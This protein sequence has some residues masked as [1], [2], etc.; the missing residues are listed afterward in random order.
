VIP[1]AKITALREALEREGIVTFRNGSVV[2]REVNRI[3]VPDAEPG[4]DGEPA[5]IE[6]VHFVV[7]RGYGGETRFTEDEIRRA[8]EMALNGP[9]PKR[10][11]TERD[12]GSVPF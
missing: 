10:Q 2:E 12:F 9:R 3:P 6:E 5:Y 4:A 7:K 11:P 1:E 8:Y